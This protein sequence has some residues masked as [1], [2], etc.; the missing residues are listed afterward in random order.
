M[1]TLFATKMAKSMRGHTCAQIFVSDK[2][3]VALYPMKKE[4]EYFL[5]LKEFAKDV[6][7][8]GVLVCDWAKTQKKQEVRD[9]CTQI[10]TTLQ[11]LKAETQWENR[12]EL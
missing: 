10:S 11:I 4:S 1:D 9:F 6:G 7:A 8:P 12:A 2:D 5:A 3:F